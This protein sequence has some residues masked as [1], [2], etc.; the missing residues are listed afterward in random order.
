MGE[1]TFL[2]LLGLVRSSGAA[3]RPHAANLDAIKTLFDR[4]VTFLNVLFT[5]IAAGWFTISAA[6]IAALIADLTGRSEVGSQTSVDAGV[7]TTRKLFE[8]VSFGVADASLVAALIVLALSAG[9][10]LAVNRALH[11]RLRRGYANAVA[12]YFFLHRLLP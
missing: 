10:G 1:I 4:E 6:L 8:P 9:V 12:V 11:G 3:T 2:W 7:E 5:A